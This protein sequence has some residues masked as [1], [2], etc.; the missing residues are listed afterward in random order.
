MQNLKLKVQTSKGR[1]DGM[2]TE[3]QEGGPFVLKSTPSL[4][5]CP[6]S[7]GTR[8]PRQPRQVQLLAAMA[9]DRGHGQGLEASASLDPPAGSYAG[10]CPVPALLPS[11][12]L[13]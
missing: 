6:V 7:P 4:H 13:P 12:G 10:L 2:A 3:G 5:C 11:S 8:G 9:G 1:K